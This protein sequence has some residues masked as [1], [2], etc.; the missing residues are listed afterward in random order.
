MS[1]PVLETKHKWKRLHADP[2]VI[3][4]GAKSLALDQA[5]P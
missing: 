4:Y 1:E 3:I 2:Q 5:A